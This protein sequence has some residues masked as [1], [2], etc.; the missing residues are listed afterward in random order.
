M[1]IVWNHYAQYSGIGRGTP[2]L[3]L[4]WD[5]TKDS[6]SNRFFDLAI[7]FVADPHEIHFSFVFLVFMVS[8]YNSY[9]SYIHALCVADPHEIHLSIVFLQL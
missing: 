2:P 3:L 1:K 4:D 6:D 8:T 5:W 7:V 9:N